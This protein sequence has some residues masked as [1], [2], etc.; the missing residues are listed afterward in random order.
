MVG[1]YNA[2]QYRALQGGER[3]DTR[4]ALKHD[5]MESIVEHMHRLIG[6]LDNCNLKNN[7]FLPKK[8]V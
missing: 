7:G 5:D 3:V 2:S 8:Q 6:E 4:Q 1:T